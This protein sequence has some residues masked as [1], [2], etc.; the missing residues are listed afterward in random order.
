MKIL[1]TALLLTTAFPAYAD[2]SF[3][4]AFSPYG[5]AANLIVSQIDQ[6][7]VS[8]HMAAYSFTSRY[9]IEALARAE[10]RFLDVKVVVDA[11]QRNQKPVQEAMGMGVNIRFNDHY[12][13]MHNKFMVI[14]GATVETGSFNYTASAE[15]RNAENILVIHGA[16][17]VTSKY[18]QEFQKLWVESLTSTK[19]GRS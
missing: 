13:I 2:P 9:I 19:K 16:P 3:E 1:I 4:Q 7:Q 14:D 8:I 10:K 18:E 15:K 6:A 12:A 11:G 5:E 17:D